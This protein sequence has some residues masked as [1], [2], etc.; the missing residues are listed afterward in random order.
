MMRMISDTWILDSADLAEML[1]NPSLPPNL[2]PDDIR[3]AL[4]PS[5]WNYRKMAYRSPSRPVTTIRG[6]RS[7]NAPY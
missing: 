4:R 6:F 7:T 2:E 3:A 1:D 5:A